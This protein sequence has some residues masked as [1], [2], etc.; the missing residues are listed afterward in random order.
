MIPCAAGP[1]F[2]MKSRM[3]PSLLDW[4]QRTSASSS[5]VRFETRSSMSARVRVPYISGWRWPRAFRL[6]PLIRRSLTA[7]PHLEQ[8][9]GNKELGG[10]SILLLVPCSLFLRLQPYLIIER[11]VVH[12]PLLLL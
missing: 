3:A 11:P 6:G 7:H 9:T 1:S 12:P 5:A 10:A 2:W 4:K 8:G